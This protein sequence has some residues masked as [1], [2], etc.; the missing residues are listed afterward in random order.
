MEYIHLETDKQMQNSKTHSCTKR[1][2][3]SNKKK[4]Q[5]TDKQ[6]EMEEIK[7][8]AEMFS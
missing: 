2:L 3:G 1:T 8:S 6:M 7:R 5:F 4:P